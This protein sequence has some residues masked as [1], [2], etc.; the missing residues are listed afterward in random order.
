MNCRQVE[1]LLSDLL[2]RSLPEREAR[3]VSAHLD[4][5]PACRRRREEFMALGPELRGLAE[6]PPPPRLARRAIAR[7]A[8]EGTTAAPP[9]RL[10]PG[11]VRLT[12]LGAAM[13]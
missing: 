5:C 8:A 4:A 6:L 13:S 2:E 9:R 12:P 3:M 7:W 10:F 11:A 1:P